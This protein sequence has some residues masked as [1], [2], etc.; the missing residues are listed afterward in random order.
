MKSNDLS[1]AE[2]ELILAQGRMREL[3][4]EL[5]SWKRQARALEFDSVCRLHVQIGDLAVLDVDVLPGEEETHWGQMVRW[6]LGAA[7]QNWVAKIRVSLPDGRVWNGSLLT[8]G[9]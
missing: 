6:L 5:E 9:R 8:D 2:A 7:R 3:E 4:R 1:L